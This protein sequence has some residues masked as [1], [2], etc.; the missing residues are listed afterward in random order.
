[1]NGLRNK[2]RFFNNWIFPV[3]L[4]IQLQR[5]YIKKF[6]AKIGYP[7]FD[8]SELFRSHQ[9]TFNFQMN[10]DTFRNRVYKLRKFVFKISI[11][12]V[13]LAFFDSEIDCCKLSRLS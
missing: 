13:F 1:M 3:K 11:A 9:K 5:F 4:V 10:R 7:R 8:C 12:F 6:N 2:S